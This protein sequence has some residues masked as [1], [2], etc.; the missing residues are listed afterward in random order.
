MFLKNLIEE[1]TVNETATNVTKDILQTSDIKGNLEH[2]FKKYC[3]QNNL[4]QKLPQTLS[5]L[6]KAKRDFQNKKLL[7]AEI[8]KLRRETSTYIRT[9]VE[10]LQRK[11]RFELER[12][13][14]RFKYGDK[15][16]EAILLEK[17]AFIV[18]DVD[19]KD[20]EVQKA[21][22]EKGRLTEIEKSSIEELEEA[23]QKPVISKTF[24]KK[25]I[26]ED[27]KNLFGQD[28]EIMLNY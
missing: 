2:A 24:I 6:I 5:A 3:Q 10:H 21:K 13:T 9:L 20:K 15:I 18:I 11:K 14:I 17:N 22:I 25:H 8:D 26:F 27:L 1:R 4:S 16:G 12:A 28:V 23:I 7:K 19:A